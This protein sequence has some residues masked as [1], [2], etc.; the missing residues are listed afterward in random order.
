MPNPLVIHPDFCAWTVE[1]LPCRAVV[2]VLVDH[3]SATTCRRQDAYRSDVDRVV[4]AVIDR[5]I[6]VS[7]CLG[8]DRV[9]VTIKGV[10]HITACRCSVVARWAVHAPIECLQNVIGPCW[11][12]VNVL[13]LFE[14]EDLFVNRKVL[15]ADI[16]QRR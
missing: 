7:R 1:R 15:N 3:R 16:D 12:R 9:N 11:Q 14:T 8:A 5:D 10:G 4:R 13:V 2:T 6:A